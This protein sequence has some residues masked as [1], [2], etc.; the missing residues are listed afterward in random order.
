MAAACGLFFG[1]AAFAGTPPVVFISNQSS[2]IKPEQVTAAIPAFQLSVTRDLAPV[3]G[4]DAVITEDP[5]AEKTADM[6]IYLVDDPTVY[7]ALGYHEVDLGQPVAWIFAQPAKDYHEDWRLTFS[8]EL[9]EMLV[10]PWIN[11][12]AWWNRR[13][14][15]VELCDPV[16]SGQFA[17][18]IDGV[19]MSDWITPRYYDR[20]LPGRYDFLGKLKRPGQVLNKGYKSWLNPDGS[21]GQV[22]VG[23]SR[24]QVGESR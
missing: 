11:R 13:Q 10:D 21:W 20:A 19:P 17:Y 5:A 2:L 14:W 3:W 15:L 7:G 16:E 18:F 22:L 8:H 1:P 4:T 9:D 24:F 12:F 6:V 23:F